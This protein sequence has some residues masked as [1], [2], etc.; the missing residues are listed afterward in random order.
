MKEKQILTLI[1][2]ILKYLELLLLWR[3]HGFLRIYE[4]INI[5]LVFA[6]SLKFYQ[7]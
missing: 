5:F 2:I 4:L 6:I 7:I 3:F 1:L